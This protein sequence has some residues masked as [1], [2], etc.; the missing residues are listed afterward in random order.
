MRESGG[1]G[2]RTAPSA[3]QSAV[4]AANVRE[5]IYALAIFVVVVDGVG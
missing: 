2:K 5:V 1:R 4:A 3:A